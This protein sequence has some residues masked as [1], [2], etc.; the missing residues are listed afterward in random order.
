MPTK[1]G[2]NVSNFALTTRIRTIST[3]QAWTKTGHH[4]S[5]TQSCEA[6]Q[7]E[8]LSYS[9]QN[10]SKLMDQIKR[11]KNVFSVNENM[12]FEVDEKLE[13]GDLVVK[14]WKASTEAY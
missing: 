12:S 4:G 13:A 14:D 8:R 9:K 2:S 11:K 5:S 1:S 3:L 7:E 10:E 6:G